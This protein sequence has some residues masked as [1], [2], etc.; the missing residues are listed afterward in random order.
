MSN[1]LVLLVSSRIL[2][3]N[4]NNER[5]ILIKTSCLPFA[6]NAFLHIECTLKKKKRN[7][8]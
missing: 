5:L 6:E 2:Y 1:P 3:L 7:K 4:N 8:R